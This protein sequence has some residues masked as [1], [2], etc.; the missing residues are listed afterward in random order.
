VVPNAV[1][2]ELFWPDREREPGGVPLIVAV[3]ALEPVKGVEDLVEAVGLLHSRRQD[4]RVVLIGE[5][6]LRKTLTRRI[7][8]LGLRRHL[9]L[10]G[11]LVH[12]QVAEMMRSASFAVVPSRW[13]TFSVVVGEAMACGL[14]VVATAVG[15]VTER[16]DAG[17]GL[18]VDARQP[19][20][21]AD[22]L[23]QMLDGYRNYDRGAI[24]EEARVRLSPESIGS[25]WEEVYAEARAL[26]RTR[27]SRHAHRPRSSSPG[28]RR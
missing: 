13:E 11:A 5:G 15:G 18:L 25:R 2:T 19:T 17:N 1:Q 9:I 27:K 21:L 22:A 23:E 6:S 24:S 26:S 20:A 10:T 28:R 4:F 12:P 16:I 8:E 7:D 3:A 14:P